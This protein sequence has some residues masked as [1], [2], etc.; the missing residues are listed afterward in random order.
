M[1]EWPWNTIINRDSI[2]L[3]RSIACQENLN[4]Q[5]VPNRFS[6]GAQKVKIQFGSDQPGRKQKTFLGLPKHRNEVWVPKGDR[7]SYSQRVEFPAAKPLDARSRTFPWHMCNLPHSLQWAHN[8]NLIQGHS[9]GRSYLS[10]YAQS[11]S[12]RWF[13]SDGRFVGCV[14]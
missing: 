12:R 1:P 13:W 9:T 2:Y 3:R 8:P 14:K 5:S 4:F 11:V 7:I 6:K 10:G